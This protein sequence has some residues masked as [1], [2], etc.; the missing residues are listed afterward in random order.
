MYW[1]YLSWGFVY[2]I[3]DSLFWFFSVACFV[4]VVVIVGHGIFI[5]YSFVFMLLQVG[6]LVGSIFLPSFWE[7][8]VYC[9]AHWWFFFQFSYIY[10]FYMKFFISPF[11]VDN[12]AE[13]PVY[14]LPLAYYLQCLFNEINC[15]D[16][17]VS[18]NALM[19]PSVLRE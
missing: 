2:L 13:S 14:V 3:E 10:L 17:W 5:Y 9:L 6:L 15:V 1:I 11:L 7:V 18:W 8:V 19:Y 16:W 12:S 4:I